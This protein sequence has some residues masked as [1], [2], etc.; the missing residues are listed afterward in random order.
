MRVARP[1][2]PGARR[3]YDK[4]WGA[5]IALFAVVVVAIGTAVYFLFLR[6]DAPAGDARA[7][8]DGAPVQAD[9][10]AVGAGAAGGRAFQTPISVTVTAGGDGL[11]TFRV[12]A[13]GTRAP[14]WID[15]GTAKTFTADSSLVIEGEMPTL[16]FADAT[17]DLQGL[18]WTPADGRPL[19]ISR[20]TGQ[21][22]LDSL[23]AAPAAPAPAAAP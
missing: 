14:H 8:A 11:Q 19:V 10:A 13:D 2:V 16:R 6:P 18:R 7:A 22:L 15:A 12:S 23:A 9:S 3:S 17:L 5:I 1:A 4:N 20:A 21:R